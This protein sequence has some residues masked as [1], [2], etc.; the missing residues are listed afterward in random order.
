MR[1]NKKLQISLLVIFG[2]LI[3]AASL[4]FGTSKKES[5]SKVVSAS[6]DAPSEEK[7]G[8]EYK[9]EGAP[10]DPKKIVIPKI[11][12]DSF[13][14]KVGVDSNNQ[15]AVPNNLFV[16]GWFVNSASPGDKGLSVID[17]HVTGRKNDGVF[18]NLDM[19]QVGDT[20]IIEYGSG[21][22]KQFKVIGKKSVAEKDSIGIIFSQNSNVSN[23]VNLVTCSGTFDEAT[24]SYSER[25]VVATQLL[26]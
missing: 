24:R 7:P 17:G 21:K 6:T 11:N 12:V 25:L 22:K 16:V 4:Y 15:I 19:L 13:V 9:W 26:P 20:Y 8:N 14:Q 2:L 5:Q 18:K 3:V 1:K 23:Q 10:S